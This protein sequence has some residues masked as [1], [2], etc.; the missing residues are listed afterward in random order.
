[1][2]NFKRVFALTGAVIMLSSSIAFADSDSG[3]ASSTY[4]DLHRVTQASLNSDNVITPMWDGYTYSVS[5]QAQRRYEDWSLIHNNADDV[6]DSV[7]Y[8]VAVTKRASVT[9]GGEAEFNGLLAKGKYSANAT[10][11]VD[12]T[13]NVSITWNLPKGRW[14][15]SA[16]AMF[17]KIVG[18]KNYHINGQIISSQAVTADYTYDRYSDQVKQ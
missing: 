17:N 16:G 7:T 9:L 12:T 11:G 2:L 3:V 18:Y 15:L 4:D 10:V 6:S 14:R 8:S 1:M 5:T 13:T